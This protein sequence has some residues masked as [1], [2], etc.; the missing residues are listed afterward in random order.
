M[1]FKKCYF[2]NSIFKSKSKNI[3]ILKL[4]IKSNDSEQTITVLKEIKNVRCY[5]EIVFQLNYIYLLK[6]RFYFCLF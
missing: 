5:I 3:E 6:N 2:N 1:P 4:L